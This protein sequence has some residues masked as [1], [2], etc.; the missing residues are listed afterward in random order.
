MNRSPLTMS[1][2]TEWTLGTI[3]AIASIAGAVAVWTSGQSARHWP[4]PALVLAEWVMLG[5]AALV[6]VALD[7]ER[8][9]P[10]WG[11]LTWSSTGAL[12][13]SA[14]LGFLEIGLF[15]FPA[16]LPLGGAALLA[17]KRKHRH[18]LSHLG[19]AAG[20]GVANLLVLLWIVTTFGR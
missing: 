17:D 11:L 19:L 6:G 7:D 18:V 14:V 8:R 9:S 12:F 13:G 5:L 3:G 10:R 20:I 4:F 15:A 2:T 16:V 1:R